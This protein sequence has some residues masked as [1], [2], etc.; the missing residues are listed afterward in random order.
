[1]RRHG[2]DAPVVERG[3]ALCNLIDLATVLGEP[4]DP[5]ATDLRGLELSTDDRQRIESELGH[6]PGLQEWLP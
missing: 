4:T 3:I 6:L 1:M 5:W 2:A